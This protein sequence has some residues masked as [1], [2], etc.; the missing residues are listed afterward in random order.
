M[1]SLIS[2]SPP[3]HSINSFPE[4]RDIINIRVE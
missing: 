4:T 2:L 3:V 1:N